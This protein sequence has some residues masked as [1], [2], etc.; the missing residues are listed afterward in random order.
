[1]LIFKTDQLWIIYPII[2]FSSLLFERNSAGCVWICWVTCC[3]VRPYPIIITCIPLQ[4]SILI[5]FNI[6]ADCCNLTEWPW[7]CCRPLNL[8]SSLVCTVVCP[9]QIYLSWGYGRCRQVAWKN[10]CLKCCCGRCHH[11]RTRRRPNRS[12]GGSYNDR[13]GC[14]S[15]GSGGYGRSITHITDTISITIPLVFNA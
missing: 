4:S 13:G 1:M 8:E 10:W 15:Y 14:W 6:G 9:A 11:C 2:I 7:W 12:S 5:S 3:I